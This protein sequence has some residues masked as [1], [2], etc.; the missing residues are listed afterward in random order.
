MLT[1]MG[2][3]GVRGLRIVR[4]LGGR[5]IAQDQAS[6]AVF[7]MPKAVADEGLAD[8]IMPLPSIAAGLASIAAISA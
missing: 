2:S 6:A 8:E 3:D 7:G 5:I 4:A 1:G